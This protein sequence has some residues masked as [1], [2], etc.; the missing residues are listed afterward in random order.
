M[1]QDGFTVKKDT[2]LYIVLV[3]NLTLTEEDFVK[4]P[5]AGIQI[6]LFDRTNHLEGPQSPPPEVPW[7][8]VIVAVSIGGMI[9]ALCVAATAY[10]VINTVKGE[11][12]RGVQEAAATEQDEDRLSSLVGMGR[13]PATKQLDAVSEY[14]DTHTGF[15]AHKATVK[16]LPQTLKANMA[17]EV[18]GYGGDIE[19]AELAGEAT[20]KREKSKGALRRAEK[21]NDLTVMED[22]DATMMRLQ[23]ANYDQSPMRHPLQS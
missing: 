18:V 23:A 22:P 21:N 20:P 8:V 10:I 12:K 13:G 14:Y 2:T 11:R 6:S 7:T 4:N 9:T 5:Q 16:V 15:K 1:L 17:D 19:M 3:R